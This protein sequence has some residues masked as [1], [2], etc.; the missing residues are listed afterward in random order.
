MEKMSIQEKASPMLIETFKETE[1]IIQLKQSESN[2]AEN[3]SKAF[4][5]FP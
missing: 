2:F 5:N 4:Y 1:T 3:L